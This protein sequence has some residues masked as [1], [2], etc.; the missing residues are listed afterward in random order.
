MFIDRGVYIDTATDW[1]DLDYVLVGTESELVGILT[2]SDVFARLNDFAEAFVLIY[3]IE[4]EV[5]DLIIDM[6]CDCGLAPLIAN[7]NLAPNTR[8]LRAVTDFTFD[9]YPRSFARKPTGHTSKRPSRQF[10]KSRTKT[11][12][13][14]PSCATLC[15]TFAVA[16]RQGTPIGSEDFAM[17]YDMAG[18]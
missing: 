10:A 16:S 18:I 4:H 5:R 2:V 3:E 13:K 14:S 1:S 8:P 9:Q 12:N 11:S 15:F 6:S 7:M 17:H